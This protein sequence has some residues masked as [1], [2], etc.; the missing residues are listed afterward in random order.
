MGRKA[1]KGGGGNQGGKAHG[2][3]LGNYPAGP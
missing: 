1:G 3:L 2:T